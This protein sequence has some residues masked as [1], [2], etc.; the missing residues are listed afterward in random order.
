[1]TTDGI[2]RRRVAAV[3]RHH[4][5]D[6]VAIAVALTISYQAAQCLMAGRST[7]LG[8]SLAPAAV[9]PAAGAFFANSANSSVE[10]AAAP[11]PSAPSYP[12]RGEQGVGR[13]ASLDMAPAHRCGNTERGESPEGTGIPGGRASG[14]RPATQPSAAMPPAGPKS[15][16]PMRALGG[17]GLIRAVRM[18]SDEAIAVP[19]ELRERG[20]RDRIAESER[21]AIDAAV[22]AG[23]VTRL[24]SDT[25]C[26]TP[27][28]RPPPQP[29][30]R[31]SLH[32]NQGAATRQR[33]AL[34]HG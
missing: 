13:A 21:A 24:D 27:V 23:R 30:W 18:V 12:A 8:R 28:H 3:L 6:V 16:K 31:R 32:A 14:S 22:A 9:P 17:H 33:K 15:V 26:D 11:A 25:R 7:S 20:R 29:K 34:G 5:D 1:M 4:G 19:R 10:T 2:S